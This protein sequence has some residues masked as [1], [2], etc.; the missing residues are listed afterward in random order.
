MGGY[1]KGSLLFLYVSWLST[2][3]TGCCRGMPIV[4]IGRFAD[5]C[6]IPCRKNARINGAGH[7]SAS[8]C[9]DNG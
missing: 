4:K 5:P 6:D 3:L 1:T 7:D 8:A 2:D 9:W